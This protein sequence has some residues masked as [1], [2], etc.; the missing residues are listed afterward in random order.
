MSRKTITGGAKDAAGLFE[1]L[2]QCA[3]TYRFPRTR[4]H[5]ARIIDSA[6]WVGFNPVHA[7]AWLGA[8]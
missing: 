7:Y 8:L 4:P 5:R 3:Q 6:N 1:P 2:S